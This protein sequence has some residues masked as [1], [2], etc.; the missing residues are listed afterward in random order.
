MEAVMT[1]SEPVVEA[2]MQTTST[3]INRTNLKNT[4]H[5]F[6]MAQKS[7]NRAFDLLGVMTDGRNGRI[8]TTLGTGITAANAAAVKLIE[9]ERIVAEVQAELEELYG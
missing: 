6:G 8:A 7:L 3:G 9:A 4:V 2:V 1:E 5:H